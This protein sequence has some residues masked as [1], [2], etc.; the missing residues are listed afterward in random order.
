MATLK[1]AEVGRYKIREKIGDGGLAVVYK[2]TDTH[3]DTEVAVKF[4]MLERLSL[5]ASNII[6]NR[7]KLEAQKMAQLSHPNIV[8]V[9]DFGVHQGT[10]FLVMPYMAG[11]SLYE[12]M[13]KP[14][15][16]RE[17]L[18]TLRP[19]MEAL[20]YTHKKNMVHRDIKPSNILITESGQPMLSDFGIVKILE[21][22]ETMDLTGT[23]MGMGTAEYMAPEQADSIEVDARADVY[24]MGVLLFEM[25]TGKKPF[26]AEKNETPV[27]IMIR[28]ARD[29][30]PSVKE[31][32]PTLPDDVVRL[33]ETAL[34]KETINR[35]QDMSMFL[36][37]LIR[38]L[39]MALVPIPPPRPG[40][41]KRNLIETLKQ[42][43]ENIAHLFRRNLRYVL[44]GILGLSALVALSIMAVRF[45]INSFNNNRL[46]VL[47]RTATAQAKTQMA[48]VTNTPQ[49]TSSPIPEPSPVC[50]IADAEL[51]PKEWKEEFCQTF[52][53]DASAEGWKVNKVDERVAVIS[54]EV[55]QGQLGVRAVAERPTSNYVTAPVS[56]LRDFVISVEGRMSSH[57]GN[58]YHDWGIV[59]KESVDGYYIFKIDSHK[60]YNFQLVRGGEVS[61]LSGKN[62]QE[63]ILPLDQMNRLTVLVDNYVFKLYINGELI[64]EIQDNRWVR[65]NVGMYI[66]IGMN[67]TVDWEFDNFAIFTP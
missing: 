66:K 60:N 26:P 10:P 11:G 38:C 18:M 1:G 47:Y 17:S 54:A 2:A 44:I 41:K 35:Y 21:S 32:V 46:E 30:L 55:Y 58:P 36:D 63:V 56:D 31:L 45:I 15:P 53:E 24:A 43:S 57:S 61:S 62:L 28:H 6:R 65:G 8:R 19:I 40:K 3:L 29:P 52:S 25:V 7:F 34:E 16:W 42:Y 14:I 50:D 37:A 12:R 67:A 39:G 48:Q 4:L 51:V 49:P 20:A 5:T 27:S 33:I 23:S 59:L 64:D 13:G 22:E 9:T